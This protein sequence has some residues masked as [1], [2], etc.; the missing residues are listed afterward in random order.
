MEF[1]IENPFAKLI[2][3]FD[4]SHHT[5]NKKGNACTLGELLDNYNRRK[6]FISDYDCNVCKT[7]ATVHNRVRC[8]PRVLCI[9][10]SRGSYLDHKHSICQLIFHLKT[11]TQMNI[12]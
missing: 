9:A 1:E 7:Q 8:Y 2:L 3:Y 5:D 10:L 6:D 12:H 4:D 11:S